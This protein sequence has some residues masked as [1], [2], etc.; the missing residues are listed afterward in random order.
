M[1]TDRSRGNA[2]D[3]PGR[4]R[5]PVQVFGHGL[6]GAAGFDV[7]TS[8]RTAET[9][10]TRE[11]G[12]GR[13]RAPRLRAARQCGSP[14]RRA[15]QRRLTPGCGL[16]RNR[17]PYRRAAPNVGAER[18]VDKAGCGP[19]YLDRLFDIVGFGKRNAGG[20]ALQSE[21]PIGRGRL[22][23]DEACLRFLL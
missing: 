14:L 11:S 23:R 6:A 4:G 21:Q 16:I 15:A 8:D 17:A 13:H 10:L 5:P 19:P 18:Q 22:L 9:R 20:G 12:I 1:S 7:Q 2:A 3:F